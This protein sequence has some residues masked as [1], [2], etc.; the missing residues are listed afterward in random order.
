MMKKS[1]GKTVVNVFCSRCALDDCVGICE[2]VVVFVCMFQ[3]GDH[4]P[5]LYVWTLYNHHEVSLCFCSYFQQHVLYVP[6]AASSC[7]V[8]CEGLTDLCAAWWR[9]T[10][11]GQVSRV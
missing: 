3:V 4:H 2:S 5:D 6:Q 11:A 7:V 8:L 10:A 9:D 1:C